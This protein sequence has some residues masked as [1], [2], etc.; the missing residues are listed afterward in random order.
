MRRRCRGRERQSVSGVG[1]RDLCAGERADQRCDGH[2][3]CLSALSGRRPRLPY[4]YIGRTQISAVLCPPTC[5]P[6]PRRCRG[7]PALA[8]IRLQSCV[9]RRSPSVRPDRNTPTVSNQRVLR[10]FAQILV[11][12]RRRCIYTLK[13]TKQRVLARF[14]RTQ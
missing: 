11:D 2:S 10:R 4:T 7:A 9:R 14:K 1:E 13:R 3:G 5:R 8:Q 6:M 12:R